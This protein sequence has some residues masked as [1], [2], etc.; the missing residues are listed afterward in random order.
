M[1]FTACMSSAH[2]S[3]DTFIE[4]FNMC[5]NLI[6]YCRNALAVLGAGYLL[7]TALQ[8]AYILANGMH[9]YFLAPRGLARLN[10]RKYG[11]WA[12]KYCFTCELFPGY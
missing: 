1:K 9:A 3:P 8:E 4:P 11:E 5:V 6:L 7:K 2:H 10:L 12:G